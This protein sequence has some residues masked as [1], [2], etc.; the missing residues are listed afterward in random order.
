M[1]SNALDSCTLDWHSKLLRSNQNIVGERACA[2]GS[3][4]STTER[5]RT[6]AAPLPPADLTTLYL[7]SRVLHGDGP[8]L[9]ED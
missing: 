8:V 4:F 3:N 7:P 9:R 6:P 2:L 1:S 5:V